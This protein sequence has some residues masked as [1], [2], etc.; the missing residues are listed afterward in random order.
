M[1]SHFHA[2]LNDKRRRKNLLFPANNKLPKVTLSLFFIPF[3]SLEEVEEVRSELS[4]FEND[5]FP[6]C[7]FYM[8]RAK[9]SLSPFS[10]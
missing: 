5:P 8:K 4:F 3:S 2:R 6:F 7:M 10:L 1:R 9:V